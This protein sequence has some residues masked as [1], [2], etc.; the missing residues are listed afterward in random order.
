MVVEDDDIRRACIDAAQ[1]HASK[2]AQQETQETPQ[3]ASQSPPILQEQ[4]VEAP[5]ADAARQR[6]ENEPNRPIPNGPLC[7]RRKS[8]AIA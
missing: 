7:A 6:E 4:R 8:G 5:S 1:R 3:Q 2:L